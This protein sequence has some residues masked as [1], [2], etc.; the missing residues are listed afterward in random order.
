MSIADRAEAAVKGMIL[1]V[2]VGVAALSVALAGLGFLIAGLFLW[3]KQARSAPTAAA[4]TGGVLLLVAIGLSVI[5]VLVLRQ[6][7]RRQPRLMAELGGLLGIATSLARLITLAIRSDMRKSLV[8][9][10]IAGAVTEYISSPGK[11][12]D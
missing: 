9:A 6:I 5:G 7:R 10:M 4:I 12:N 1:W 2:G 3:L 8:L 11:R